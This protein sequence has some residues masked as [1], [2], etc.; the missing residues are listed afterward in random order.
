M[1][2]LSI[3]FHFNMQSSSS[4]EEEE[5]RHLRAPPVFKDPTNFRAEN[6]REK[7]TFYPD[8]T[9]QLETETGAEKNANSRILVRLDSFSS[10]TILGI[11][12]YHVVLFSC[13]II[14]EVE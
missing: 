6:F 4:N 1:W 7:L 8:A 12:C 11:D 5:Q 2:E 10:P 9:E 13:C 14:F 3:R